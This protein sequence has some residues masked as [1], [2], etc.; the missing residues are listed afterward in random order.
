MGGITYKRVI[1]TGGASGIGAGVCRELARRGCSVAIADRAITQ[2][3][4]LAAALRKDGFDA[5]SIALDVSDPD[6]IVAI[7]S[8]ISP[9]EAPANA[10]VNCA[11][12]NVRASNLDFELEDW[13]RILDVNLRG[14]ALMG[15][16]FARALIRMKQSGAV[17]NVTSML[18]HYAAPNLAS[19]ASSKG[20]VAMLTRSQAVEWGP[21]GIRVNAVSPGYVETTLTSKIFSVET[22]RETIL[23]RTPMGRLGQPIDLAKVVAFLISDDSQFVTGQIIPV[24]GGITAGE[25]ALGPPSHHDLGA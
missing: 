13:R 20:A 15:R 21:F 1:V 6:A 12:I 19:Y 5:R 8:R 7:F 14:T 25:P 24:D 18:A 23:R 9:E 10:L 3:E 2:A 17:V 11:G 4:A 22:Y 16:E